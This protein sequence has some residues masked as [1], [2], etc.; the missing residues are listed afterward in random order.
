ME[1]LVVVWIVESRELQEREGTDVG[2]CEGVAEEVVA[3]G[4][5]VIEAVEGGDHL[6]LE[7]GYER[8]VGVR[9][10]ELGLDLVRRTLPGVVEPVDEVEHVAGVFR[11]KR[12]LG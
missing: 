3:A 9:L 8:G 2:G 4:E 5:H 1:Q 10:A 11:V 6:L 7:L 12:R